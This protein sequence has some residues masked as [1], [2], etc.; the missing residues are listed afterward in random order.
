V[1]QHIGAPPVCVEVV[2]TA[3]DAEWLADLIRAL[4]VDRLA[5]CGQITDPFRTIYRRDGKV[6]DEP[7]ARAALHTQTSLVSDIVDRIDRDHPGSVTNVVPM[8]LVEGNDE[9]LRWIVHET[10]PGVGE[11]VVADGDRQGRARGRWFS[12][13][14]R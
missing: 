1:H 3:K 13:H 11:R 12:G 2:I 14:H 9:Y 6:Q 4:V 8:Q 5:A 10:T 7:Q